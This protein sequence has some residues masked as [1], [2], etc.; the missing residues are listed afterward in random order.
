[1]R[2]ETRTVKVKSGFG[3]VFCHIDYDPKDGTPTGIWF[4]QHQKFRDTEIG[5]LLESM[6]ISSTS[7]LRDIQGIEE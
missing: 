4:S 7:V 3:S 5:N 6:A 1:M 2:M